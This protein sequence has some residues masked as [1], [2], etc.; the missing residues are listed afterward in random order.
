MTRHSSASD[1]NPDALFL[2]PEAPF[3]PIGGGPLRSAS[4]LEYL[5]RSYAVHAVVFHAPCD[6]DPRAAIPPGRI[7]KWDILELPHHSKAPAA[8][9]ARNALRAIRARPPLMDRFLGCEIALAALLEDRK[10]ELAVLE[11]FWCAPYV[12]QIRRHSKR[13]VLDLH[14]VES[15]WHR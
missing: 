5:A 8:R 2:S 3:P 1:I 9:F 6:P 11:H 13:V 14:N 7:A 15:F 10:Y 4:L 12:R